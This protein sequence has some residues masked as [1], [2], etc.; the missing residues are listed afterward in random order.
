MEYKLEIGDRV[1]LTRATLLHK[2]GSLGVVTGK[3]TPH[4]AS[5]CWTVTV[6]FDETGYKTEFSYPGSPLERVHQ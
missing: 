3:F 2:E 6:R 1:R 5:G 4:H